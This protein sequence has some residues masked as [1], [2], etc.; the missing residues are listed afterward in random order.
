MIM[1]TTGRGDSMESVGDSLISREYRL[2]VK[3]QKGC[4]NDMN[5]MELG[6]NAR[7]TFFE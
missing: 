5:G 4:L 7:M 1:G 3:V 6:N 2:E